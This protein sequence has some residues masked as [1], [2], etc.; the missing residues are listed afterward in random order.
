WVPL[1]RTML[2]PLVKK[3]TASEL[4]VPLSPRPE[5]LAVREALLFRC[6]AGR[7][8]RGWGAH[9]SRRATV[10]VPESFTGSPTE[11]PL[12]PSALPTRE[13]SPA[14]GPVIHFQLSTFRL[15]VRK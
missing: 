14:A 11:S 3:G 7:L 2:A 8:S 13:D 9:R 4:V 6:R 10:L 5:S 15:S 1:P 12:A